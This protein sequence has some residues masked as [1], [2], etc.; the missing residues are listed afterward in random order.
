M[1]RIYFKRGM[2]THDYDDIFCIPKILIILI[3]PVSRM[4]NVFQFKHA[5]NKLKQFIFY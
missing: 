5:R 1:K 4:R 2:F 3:K